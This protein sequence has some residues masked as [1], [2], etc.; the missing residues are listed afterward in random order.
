MK[1]QKE[2]NEVV[3]LSFTKYEAE[4]LCRAL[5]W[6]QYKHED[7]GERVPFSWKTID[8]LLEWIKMTL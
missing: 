5:I 4:Q 3:H 6:M 2:E 8:D 7:T 1:Q